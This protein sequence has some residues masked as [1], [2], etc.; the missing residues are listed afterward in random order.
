M[1][2]SGI[3]IDGQRKS[4]G[5]RRV[6]RL[7]QTPEEAHQMPD[8]ITSQQVHL[9][10]S[11]YNWVRYLICPR[12]SGIQLINPSFPQR[13]QLLS[14]NYAIDHSIARVPTSPQPQPH[15]MHCPSNSSQGTI[16]NL[17]E[18]P[19][20]QET[21]KLCY[22]YRRR[23]TWC[24][25]ALRLLKR[26]RQMSLVVN[27]SGPLSV[28]QYYLSDKRCFAHWWPLENRVTQK[29]RKEKYLKGTA[30]LSCLCSEVSGIIMVTSR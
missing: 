4:A 18:T 24:Q 30:R 2:G 29:R 27:P 6:Q 9:N 14:A 28:L 3:H 12:I 10:F 23:R 21:P 17:S 13:E 11:L 26:G 1:E 19:T 7:S 22:I 20:E 25:V 8:H 15:G 5:C 16:D